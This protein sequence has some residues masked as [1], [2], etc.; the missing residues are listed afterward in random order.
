MLR[1]E[2]L[3]TFARAFMRS[4]A[5][6]IV[7]SLLAACGGGG[8]G[9]DPPSGTPPP[10][11]AA[12]PPAPPAPQ[13]SNKT[14]DSGISFVHR[15]VNGAN[16]KAEMFS[17]GAAAGDYDA[18]GDID[19][20]VVR[21]NVGP[22]LLYRNDGGNKFTDVAATAG[23]ARPHPAGGGYLQSGP[24]FVDLDGDADLDLFV[25]GLE[26]HPCVVFENEGNGTFRDITAQSGLTSM[27]ARNTISASFGDYD[28]DGDLDCS[29]R[30][31]GHAPAARRDRKPRRY[32]D[33][34][35]QRQQHERDPLHQRERGI[36]DCGSRC[37]ETRRLRRV[38]AQRARIR[39]LV[40]RYV[41][42]HGRRPVPGR[43]DRLGLQQ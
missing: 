43:L 17:G 39:L 14:N 3:A 34:V 12:P 26:G 32:R 8:S 10:P 31:L 4:L 6:G 13:F 19:L 18:D 9:G 36:T 15:I 5:V 23:V 27:G 16:S 11:A 38:S 24:V 40:R 28:L 21:G 7:G 2:S 25:G 20:Y 37:P 41:R 35:A 33:P 22:N 30:A 29:P 1:R 42:P